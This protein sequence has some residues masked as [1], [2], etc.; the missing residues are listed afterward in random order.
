[1][2]SI[3]QPQLGRL[4]I[5][6]MGAGVVAAYEICYRVARRSKCSCASDPRLTEHG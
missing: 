1:M 3:L 2:G 4:H 5:L 6:V